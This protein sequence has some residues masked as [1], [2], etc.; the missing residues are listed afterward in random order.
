MRHVRVSGTR[1][2]ARQA[3]Y[4]APPRRVNL[5][6][7][8]EQDIKLVHF[9]EEIA[10]N[11]R[12]FMSLRNYEDYNVQQLGLQ[13][14]SRQ[15][16]QFRTRFDN[17][18]I[19][20]RLSAIANGKIWYDVDGNLL[21]S[22]SGAALTIDFGVP[23]S[24]INQITP[25]GGSAIIDA[26][27]ATASTKIVKHINGIK[28]FSLQLTGYSLENGYACYGANIPS[29][30]ALNTEFQQFLFRNPGYNQ[31]YID[32]G[33]IPDGVL[34]FKWRRMSGSFFNDQNDAKQTM[35]DADKIVFCPP[36]SKSW[37][38]M[39]DGSYP[40]PTTYG[41]MPS[42]EAAAGT[43]DFQ[44]GMCSY[45]YPIWSPPTAM[46]AFFDTMLPWVKNP[47]VLFIADVTP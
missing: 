20:A 47:S 31:R 39:M 4:G 42:L 29:Y 35:W 36:P 28:D 1:Q 40:V 24:N 10:L 21:P 32:S 33:E 23:A 46:L 41:I 6:G 18:R 30:L 13:E 5:S 7:I 25:T 37:Y 11:V 27:W 16:L 45:A 22:S 14:I 34:G 19:G 12:D 26:S 38:T 15:A 17:G 8:S 44:Y 43:F 9:P 3:V 2:T